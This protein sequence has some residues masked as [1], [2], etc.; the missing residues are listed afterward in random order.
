MIKFVGIENMV[1]HEA[2]YFYCVSTISKIDCLLGYDLNSR[3]N[4]IGY[5]RASLLL[6]FTV[7]LSLL[8]DCEVENPLTEYFSHIIVGEYISLA[9]HNIA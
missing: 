2:F 6:M 5:I 7:Y 1:W 3:I 8:L 4:G 9:W